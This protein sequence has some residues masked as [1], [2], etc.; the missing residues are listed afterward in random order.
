M[1]QT[2]LIAAIFLASATHATACELE[3]ALSKWK[4]G[5]ALALGSFGSQDDLE[6]FSDAVN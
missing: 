6:L 1:K 4:R 5:G 3:A 2:A